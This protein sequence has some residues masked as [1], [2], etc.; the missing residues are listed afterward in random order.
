MNSGER[1]VTRRQGVNRADRSLR[2]RPRREGT[3][4]LL[5]GEAGFP[6]ADDLVGAAFRQEKSGCTAE[7]EKRFELTAID[8]NGG[9]IIQC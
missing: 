7:D 6:G 8:S 1:N 3:A 4:K 2:K 9:R 5:E